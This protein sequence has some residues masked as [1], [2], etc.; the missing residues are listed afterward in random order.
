MNRVRSDANLEAVLGLSFGVLG[1]RLADLL[2]VERELD[3]NRLLGP[4]R[5]VVVEHRDALGNG[6]EL[7]SALRRDAATNLTVSSM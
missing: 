7:V 3:V 1:C 2:E 4:Q 5:S 6:H